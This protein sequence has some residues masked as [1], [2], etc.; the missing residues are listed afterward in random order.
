MTSPSCRLAGEAQERAR[1]NGFRTE[2]EIFR[3]EVEIDDANVAT[4]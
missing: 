1:L 2:V 4:L 3:T